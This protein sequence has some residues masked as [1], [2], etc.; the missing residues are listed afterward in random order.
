MISKTFKS[1]SMMV[2]AVGF[3]VATMVSC[4]P[5]KEEVIEEETIEEVAP[6]VIEE[7]PADTMTTD[8]TA[9]DTA[10]SQ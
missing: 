1:V 2:F 4:G 6:P 8:T 10:A 3:T 5:K 7:V 9:V